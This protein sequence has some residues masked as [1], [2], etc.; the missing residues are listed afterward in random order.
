MVT[1]YNTRRIYK[2]HIY[3]VIH[4]T[5]FYVACNFVITDNYD[6]YRIDIFSTNGNI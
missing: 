3:W 6:F 2:A 4:V 1:D 5:L